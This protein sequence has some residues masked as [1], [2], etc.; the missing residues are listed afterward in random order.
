MVDA[1]GCCAAAALG[2]ILLPFRHRLAAVE[3]Y[4]TITPMENYPTIAPMENYPTIAPMENYQGVT[5]PQPSN[6]LGSAGFIHPN[7]ADSRCNW[8]LTC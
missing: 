2:I 7:L 5:L 8:E 6:M 1:A 4:P 3:N